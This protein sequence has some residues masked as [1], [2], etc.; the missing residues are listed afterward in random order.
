G[1]A[2]ESKSDGSPVSVTDLRVEDE[3]RAMVKRERPRDGFLGEERGETL[4]DAG[5]PGG[6][7][8]VVD[9]IDGTKS[10]MRGVPLFGCMIGLQIAGE[11]RLGLVAFPAISDGEHRGQTY[12]GITPARGAASGR[13]LASGGDGGSNAAADTSDEGGCWLIR[14]SNAPGSRAWSLADVRARGERCR[15]TGRRELEGATVCVT[16]PRAML[17]NNGPWLA[18]LSV[19]LGD[20]G[21]L[22]SWGDCYGHAMVASG[23]ADVMID[24]PMRIWDVAAIEPLVRGAGGVM[25]DWLGGPPGDGSRGVISAASEELMQEVAKWQSGRVAE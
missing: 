7:R 22:R 10:F 5:V 1:C 21:V 6:R 4:G 2:A 20:R 15:V 12:V 17:V 23:R 19:D 13:V 24:S 9:P 25:T 11:N 3:L 18:R 14:G 8:W 16:D